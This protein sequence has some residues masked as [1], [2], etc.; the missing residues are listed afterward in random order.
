MPQI[1]LIANR[2][3]PEARGIAAALGGTYEGKPVADMPELVGCVES[4][5]AL[6]LDTNFSESQGVDV[7]MDVLA[8][9]HIPVLMITPPDDQACAVEAMRCG[10]ASYLVKA[11]KYADLMPMALREILERANAAGHLKREIVTLRK[12]IA[13][14]EA[15]AQSL[16]QTGSLTVARGGKPKRSMAEELAARLRNGDMS[17][18]A[19]PQIALKLRELLETDVGISEIARLLSQDA[20]VSGKLLLV[21]NSAHYANARKVDTVEKAVSRVG[22]SGACNI[23]EMI[24][25]RSLYATGNP[26]YTAFFDELWVHSVACANA[27]AIVGRLVEKAASPKLFTLGLLHDAGKLA[28][29]QAISQSDPKG[30]LVA[31][32]DGEQTLR[33]FIRT[34]HVQFGVAIMQRWKFDEEFLL[35]A[36]H[37]NDLSTARVVCRSLLIVHLANLLVRARGY[38]IPLEK[39]EELE[40]APSKAYLFPAGADLESIGEEVDKAV[41]VARTLME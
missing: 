38:G 7:L 41:E 3:V 22:L 35:V 8:R 11:G 6:I 31:G 34:H 28:I 20:A 4:A 10:A 27:C 1:V 30:K 39:P 16:G 5:S 9:V 13:E 23:A 33:A 32:Q 18:P 17:L 25:N 19:Y 26:A 2:N 15:H 21:A 24:A 14:L 12:R 40:E 37:H 36:G 29:L